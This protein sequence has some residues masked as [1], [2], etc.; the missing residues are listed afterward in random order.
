MGKL[1]WAVLMLW[2]LI[3]FIVQT[4]GFMLRFEG[5]YW[6]NPIIFLVLLGLFATGFQMTKKGQWK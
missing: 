4:T 2:A 1:V 3:M 5:Y 6:F